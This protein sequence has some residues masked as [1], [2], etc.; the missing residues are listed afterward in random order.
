ME[1]PT[2]IDC[3]DIACRYFGQLFGYFPRFCLRRCT[4]GRHTIIGTGMRDAELTPSQLPKAVLCQA[5]VATASNAVAC[6]IKAAK[7]PS[8]TLGRREIGITVCVATR[9]CL[10][11]GY[12]EYISGKTTQRGSNPNNIAM[13]CYHASRGQ[14]MSKKNTIKTIIRNQWV[15][16]VQS[17]TP[18][19][20]DFALTYQIVI[21]RGLPSFLYLKQTCRYSRSPIETLHD[22]VKHLTISSI[23]V[24]A[25]HSSTSHYQV[26]DMYVS[27]GSKNRSGK[28]LIT[29]GLL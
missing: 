17:A 20:I 21:W 6:K 23:R 18:F 12:N 3:L 25:T 10:A 7:C 15:K 19:T 27:L 29:R 2:V 16:G 11:R 8:K 13:R 4:K 28:P 1:D 9:I 5:V 24:A 26:S 22:I 14:G